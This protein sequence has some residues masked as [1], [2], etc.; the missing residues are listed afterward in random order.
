MTKGLEFILSFTDKMSRG[1]Q[2]AGSFFGGFS[3][4]LSGSTV[5]LSALESKLAQLKAS[6]PFADGKT[7]CNLDR[8]I[9]ATEKNLAGIKKAMA[10]MGS[11]IDTQATI[12]EIEKLENKLRQLK[13]TRST[14]GNLLSGV[15]NEIA[16]TEKKLSALKKQLT[17]PVGTAEVKGSAGIVEKIKE[18]L[19]KLGTICKDTTQEVEELEKKLDSLKTLKE[20]APKEELYRLN[21]QIVETERQIRNLNS[22]AS[23]DALLKMALRANQVYDAVEKIGEALSFTSEISDLQRSASQFAGITKSE[24][25]LATKQAYLISESYGENSQS[26]LKA[27][28]ALTMQIG[29]SVEQNLKL[30]E[31]GFKS[32]ANLNGDFMQQLSE[33][34]PQMKKA[35]LDVSQTIALIAKTGQQG[36]YDDKGIDSIKEAAL[37]L[38]ELDAMQIDAIKGIGLDPAQMKADIDSGKKTLFE[39]MQAITAQMQTIG[40]VSKRQKIFAD[41]FKGAGEDAGESFISSLSGIDLDLSGMQDYENFGEKVRGIF[42]KLKFEVADFTGVV[43]AAVPVIAQSMQGFAMAEPALQALG[44][45]GGLAKL[46]IMRAAG[47]VVNYFGAIRAAGAGTR[48]FT[49]VLQMAKTALLAQPW[50][51]AVAAVAALGYAFYKL[52]TKVDRTTLA[53][54]KA[55]EIAGQ[56]AAKERSE[57]DLLFKQLRQTNPKSKERLDLINKLKESYPDLINGMQLE[58]ASALQISEAYDKISASI[59]KKAKISAYKEVLEEQYKEIAKLETS[60]ETGLG[61]MLSSYQAGLFA[62]RDDVAKLMAQEQMLANKGTIKEIEGTV[63]AL[64]DKIMH[65]EGYTPPRAGDVAQLPEHLRNLKSMQYGNVATV[66]STPPSGGGGVADITNKGVAEISSGG[67]RQTNITLNLGKL[68]EDINIHTQNIREG[69]D[70]VVKI[71][72]RRLL[73]TVNSVN[74]LGG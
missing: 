45:A 6:R 15:A 69:I 13:T 32:G 30:I 33:Y 20:F 65:L 71:V 56:A 74:Q 8:E 7:L 11:P 48:G 40:D 39:A 43:G 72:E 24:T 47:G 25:A 64:Q 1:L 18:A 19:R 16:E 42:A 37:S 41:I 17:E 21:E 50:L 28:N 38:S 70:E 9:E 52:A 22:T 10:Q 60:R 73:Q 12:T 67:E 68:F 5:N 4:K 54:R 61:A 31:K 55:E 23:N 49:K 59:A 36:I 44:K 63:K 51:L 66:V 58:T 53:M 57:L 34:A 35:G 14:D 46:G 62:S 27:A 29:G 2:K 3:E 26:V